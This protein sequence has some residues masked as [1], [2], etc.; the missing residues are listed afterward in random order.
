VRHASRSSG[1]LHRE[2]SQSRVSQFASKLADERWRGG[3][4]GIIMEIA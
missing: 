4:R 1:L 3:A 2:T